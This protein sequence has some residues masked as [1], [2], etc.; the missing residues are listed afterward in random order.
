MERFPSGDQGQGQFENNLVHMWEHH[1]REQFTH[2]VKC[3]GWEKVINRLHVNSGWEVRYLS[4]P[5]E[6]WVGVSF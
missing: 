3:G 6:Q 2:K 5:C 4:S 1:L